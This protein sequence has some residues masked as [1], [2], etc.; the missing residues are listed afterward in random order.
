MP[1]WIPASIPK[2]TMFKHNVNVTCISDR[3]EMI[4]STKINGN[5]LFN[6]TRIESSFHKILSLDSLILLLNTDV[7]HCT[8]GIFPLNRQK[9]CNIS[10]SV[11]KSQSCCRALQ[12]P[13]QLDSPWRSMV[14]DHLVTDSVPPGT[15]SASPL[16]SVGIARLQARKGNSLFKSFQFIWCFSLF[17]FFKGSLIIYP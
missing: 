9:V 2:P 8:P 16:I 1:R 5:L 12:C 14:K 10:S 7:L 11:V 13:Q 15:G 3:S 17:H 6:H 4:E